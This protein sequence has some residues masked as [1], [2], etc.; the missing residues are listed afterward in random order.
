MN[1]ILFIIMSIISLGF[2]VLSFRLGKIYLIGFIVTSAV[3]MNIYVTKGIYLFGLA[4]TGGNVLYASIFLSTDILNEYWGQKTAYRAVMIGFLASIF[5]LVSSQFI[6]NLTPANYDL[7][8]GAL[9][10]IFNLTPRII[11][12]SMIAYLISQNL[13]VWLYNQIKKMTRG[14]HLWLRNNGST[15]LSQLVD[16]SIFTL[17]A[18]A[19]IYPHLWQLILFTYIIKIIVAALDTPFI[20]LTK[21]IKPKEIKT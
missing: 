16:S 5:F 20:Y 18:F 8:Q 19:G 6:L 7:A 1:E 2:V 10:T 9:K 15:W 17:I 13:D 11:V 12:A 21:K 4:T 3:L 14:K